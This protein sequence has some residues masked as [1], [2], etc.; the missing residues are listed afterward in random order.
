MRLLICLLAGILQLAPP[1]ARAQDFP[2]RPIHIISPFGPGTATD[3]TARSLRTITICAPPDR[4]LIG[5]KLFTG[6]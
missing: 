3:F 2:T 6:S 4:A 5:A 1:S